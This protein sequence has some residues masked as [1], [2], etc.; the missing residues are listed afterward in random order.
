MDDIIKKIAE[1]LYARIDPDYFPDE[2][3][4][5]ELLNE[6]LEHHKVAIVNKVKEEQVSV[7]LRNSTES[8]RMRELA[9]IPHKGNFV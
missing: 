3:Q 4:M 6:I 9:G 7:L 1:N 8:K 2:H 5:A